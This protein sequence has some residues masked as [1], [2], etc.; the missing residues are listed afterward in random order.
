M[1]YKIFASTD[2]QHCAETN[3]QEG[4]LKHGHHREGVEQ[5]KILLE[6]H[7]DSRIEEMRQRQT[8]V[9][10]RRKHK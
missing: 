2:Q 8:N 6:D 3:T 9:Q 5:K 7:N 4:K 1:R 10:I